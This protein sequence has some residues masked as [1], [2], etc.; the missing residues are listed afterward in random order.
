[1]Y[2]FI[3]S[4]PADFPIGALGIC[5]KHLN[6]LF[7]GIQRLQIK[8]TSSIHLKFVYRD[9]NRYNIENKVTISNAYKRS[10]IGYAALKAYLT[11]WSLWAQHVYNITM[12]ASH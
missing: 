1:M 2:Y 5:G 11:K 8:N 12:S 10:T 6:K 7:T 3:A 4:A 9:L